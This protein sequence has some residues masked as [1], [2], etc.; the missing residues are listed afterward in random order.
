M[1]VL[2]NN[3]NAVV[4]AIRVFAV[5]AVSVALVA[6]ANALTSGNLGLPQEAVWVTPLLTSTLLG[7]D[8]WLR[9]RA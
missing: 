4:R 5:G 3:E 1:K 9:S 7:V 8:K 2:T 6:V